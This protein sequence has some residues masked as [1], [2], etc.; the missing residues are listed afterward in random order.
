MNCGVE[1]DEPDARVVGCE[2]PVGGGRGGYLPIAS[3]PVLGITLDPGALARDSY[4]EKELDA[5]HMPRVTAQGSFFR[6]M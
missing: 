3:T 1:I 2:A 4:G 5:E 6:M